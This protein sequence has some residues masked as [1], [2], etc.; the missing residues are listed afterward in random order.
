MCCPRAVLSVDADVLY[1]MDISITLAQVV[2]L[3]KS[4]RQT[5]ASMAWINT[6]A[7]QQ[8]IACGIQPKQ[9]QTSMWTLQTWLGRLVLDKEVVHMNRGTLCCHAHTQKVPT[10]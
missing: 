10:D 9:Y 6:F 7:V 5:Q 4:R 2:G 8:H 3:R 1:Q